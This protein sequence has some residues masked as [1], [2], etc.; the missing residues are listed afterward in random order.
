ML[1]HR[2][3]IEIRNDESRYPISDIR[4]EIWYVWLLPQWR[5]ACKAPPSITLYPT[6]RRL[7]RREMSASQSPGLAI[8]NEVECLEDAECSIQKND[9]GSVDL[10]TCVP[11][12]ARALGKSGRPVWITCSKPVAVG[13]GNSC[14]NTT[15]LI[16][17]HTGP[18]ADDLNREKY[19]E[20]KARHETMNT[21][22]LAPCQSKL[23]LQ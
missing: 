14:S 3:R 6:V 19:E 9:D 12:K 23:P 7:H 8:E 17:F 15:N 22:G 21:R 16:I 11:K 2:Y 1:I 18:R 20:D 10:T 4:Y 5:I 13:C